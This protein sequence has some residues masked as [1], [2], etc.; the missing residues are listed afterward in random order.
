MIYALSLIWSVI[1]I[2]HYLG[3]NERIRKLILVPFSKLGKYS[4]DIFLFH[5]PLHALIW[6]H[7]D[8]MNLPGM[9]AKPLKF[10][11]PLLIPIAGRMI[12][13]RIRKWLSEELRPE[14]PE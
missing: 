12:Y 13:V 14:I 7:I 8:Q 11:L 9:L 1:V 2:L 10:L 6:P 4:L 5:I 3:K